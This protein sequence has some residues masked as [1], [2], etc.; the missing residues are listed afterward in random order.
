MT[1]R[2]DRPEFATTMRGYDRLQVDN[3]IEQ[4]SDYAAEAEERVETAESELEF[5]RHTTVGPRVAQIL[6]LAV[7]EAKA[8]RAGVAADAEEARAAAR[9]EAEDIVAAAR[10]DAERIVAEANDTREEILADADAGREETLAE[11]ER[12]G[13]SK[14]RLLSDL[15]GLQEILAQATGVMPFPRPAA[16]ASTEEPPARPSSAAGE[17]G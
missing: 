7:E 11:V 5:S 10:V 15:E 8:L 9:R 13:E 3:Y 17:A 2:P 14:N 16:P 4:L 6:D 1:H 12:L